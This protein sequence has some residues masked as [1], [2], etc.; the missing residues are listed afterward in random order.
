MRTLY[1]GEL[2]GFI[3]ENEKCVVMFGASWCSPCKSL[4]PRVAD[5]A[6]KLGKIDRI[7][8]ADV[9]DLADDI[10]SLKIRSVPTL[11][12]FSGGNVVMTSVGSTLDPS[13]KEKIESL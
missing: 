12:A 3:T 6:T 13:M 7:V 11:I 5:L 2:S 4:K 8:Y 10:S 1:A 9:D